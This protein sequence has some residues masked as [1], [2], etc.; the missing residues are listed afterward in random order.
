[1]RSIYRYFCSEIRRIRENRFYLYTLTLFPAIALLIFVCYFS[2]SGIDLLPIAVTDYDNS[3]LSRKVIEMINISPS[4]N[5]EYKTSSSDQSLELMRRGK[6][7]ASILIPNNFERDILRNNNTHI[8]LYNSGTNI[9]TNGFI[10]K[11]VQTA[12]KSFGAG[13]V[14]E[15]L[16]ARGV[17]SSHALSMAMPVRLSEHLLFNPWLNYTYYLAPCFLAMM[18]M[19]FTSLATSIAVCDREYYSFVQI[20]GVILPTNIVMTLFATIILII[21]FCWFQVPLNGNLLFIL[22]ATYL[23]IITYQAIAIFIA[24]ITKSLHLTLSLT[25]GYSVLAF[26]FSGLTF[27]V[28]AMAGPL[29]LLTHLFPFTYYINVF[30]DQA[31]RGAPLYVSA[32]NLAYM[33]IFI[34]LPLFVYKRLCQKN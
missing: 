2:K 13:V 22:L 21:L 5:I 14:I 24:G 3:P 33:T 10:E 20:I 11:A 25:G 19:I 9:S 31:L 27:P 34:I 32:P 16:L 8:E 18:I 6:I 23:L 7:Y 1:M 12:A 29:Q 28:L 26:T 15:T 30:I 17:D 4:V